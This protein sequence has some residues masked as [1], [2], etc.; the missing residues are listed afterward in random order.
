M[1]EVVLITEQ[2]IIIDFDAWGAE[3]IHYKVIGGKQWDSSQ[4]TLLADEME[5]EMATHSSTLAWKIPRTEELGRLPSRGSH[6]VRHDWSDL[7]AADVIM[8]N[9][10]ILV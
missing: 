7:A 5:K 9:C 10:T 1:D 2:W 8:K 4:L 3:F 6:R